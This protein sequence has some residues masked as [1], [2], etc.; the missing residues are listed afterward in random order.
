MTTLTLESGSLVDIA[1][2]LYAFVRDEALKGT[3]MTADEV[4]RT[5]GELMEEFEPKNRELLA[6]RA[7]YQ[8]KIDEYYIKKRK[9]GWEPTQES[10]DVDAAEF[11]RFLVGIGYLGAEKPIDFKMTTPQLDSEMDQNG[12]ELVT[13]VTNA[14]MA[15][16]GANARWGSLY[17]AYY[18]SDIHSEIDRETQRAR[19]LQ[20]VVEATNTFLDTYVA[21]WENGVRIGDISSYS[22]RI[23]TEGRYE[24]V[25]RTS[26]GEEVRLQDPEKFLGFNTGED[27]QLTEFFLEDNGLKV[28]IQLYDGGKVH[29][30]NGQFRDIIAESAV[31][32]IID[33]EDAVAIVDAEDMVLAL[34]NYLGLIK[35]DLQAYGSGGNL[36]AMNSDKT[37][38][39][40]SGVK[41]TLK[42]TSLMSVRNV[43]LHMYTDMVK[44]GGQ[45]I[46]ERI[47]GVFLTTFIAT[48]QDKGSKGEPRGEGHEVGLMPVRRPNSSE[49][50][51][52]QVTPKLQTAEEV[53]EQV[54]FFEAVEERLGLTKGTILIGIMN[55]EIG[56]TLQLAESLSAAQDRI[57][58]T[59][60]GFLDRT[61][62][63][64]RAQMYAGPVDFRDDLTQATFNTSY[65]LHNV[66]VSIQAR[67]HERGKIGKG[68]W[69]RN[70]AIA[71]MLEKKLDHPRTGGN[72][73]WVPAPY[74]SHIHSMH[75]HMVDV[76]EVQRFM[77]DSPPMDT[78]RKALLT[79]PLLN[80]KKSTGSEAIQDY[81]LRYAHSM[82]AYV[83]PWV[84]RGIGCS[85]V[86]NFDQV[87]EMKDRATERID[88]AII[89]NW[90]LH[91]VVTQ[92]E[93]E[94]AVT[95]ATEIVD[96]QNS[97]KP[98]Y[99]PGT[100]SQE[101][102]DYVLND[103]AIAAV[104]QI[105]DESLSSPSAYVEPALFRNRRRVKAA[106]RIAGTAS[107]Y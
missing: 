73:A 62:S 51:V 53:A 63:Q 70:R 59:N 3:D 44:V 28:Q 82:V 31:T 65:E 66:D 25:G 6:K 30:E 27:Q 47:L 54:R 7:V 72:T 2:V 55:E 92:Q 24:L 56:M 91:N 46:P 17:D 76:D 22:V 83:G 88:G 93:I 10:G 9:G 71:E 5:L 95:R 43:S 106:A 103:P 49:G 94:N 104:L 96:E 98:D 64:I 8:S 67:V 48:T 35:G 4:F 74:S 33:F 58:F 32:N 75:Y 12:P 29:E 90:K 34:R 52:Y 81:L 100:D 26:E 40:A 38:V 61:G 1:E 78:P 87:E 19:R 50:Y 41:Q 105:I 86:P 20:M 11:E 42:G 68:M 15:V 107:R 23:K 36:K 57:F 18:L 84:H 14:S 85:G 97:G 37:Y 21:K 69:V 89:A 39:D 80:T 99:L 45:D 16:G 79:F 101:K 60:T 102:Q 77:E 13:P